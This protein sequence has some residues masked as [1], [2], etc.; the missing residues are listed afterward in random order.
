MMKKSKLIYVLVKENILGT[1]EDN[2]LV[3]YF[4]N[5]NIAEMFVES[6]QGK[7]KNVH[8]FLKELNELR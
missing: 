2:V 8:Y 5:K 1:A 3:G 6:M 4:T 7:D